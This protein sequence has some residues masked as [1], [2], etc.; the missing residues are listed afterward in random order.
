MS[1]KNLAGEAP[2]DRPRVRAD[3]NEET[4]W[5]HALD[6]APVGVT[7][8]D[9][10][11]PDRPLVYANDAVGQL[12]GY[13]TE[14]LLGRDCRFL[15]GVRGEST[16]E[17]HGPTA[18][19]HEA[20]DTGEAA[21]EEVKTERADG[22]TFWNEVTHVPIMAD[23]ELSS[24]VCFHRDVTRGRALER[25]HREQLEEL[26]TLDGMVSHS[27]R[28]DLQLVLSTLELLEKDVPA[29]RRGDI[30]AALD[31]THQAIA[32]AEEARAIAETVVASATDEL[33]LDHVIP[34]EVD[35][36]QQSSPG[37]MITV[38]GELPPVSVTANEMF[39]ALVRS[40]LE[41]EIVR[42]NATEPELVVSA[43]DDDGSVVVSVSEDGPEAGGET[44]SRGEMSSN[45]D[46]E[47]GTPKSGRVGLSLVRRLVDSYGGDV[48]DDGRAV[49]VTLPIGE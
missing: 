6:A 7:I 48:T 22:T 5:K 45:D 25:E 15:F 39:P 37:A 27:I 13:D 14:T 47:R 2:V 49:H 19:L 43:V 12:T 23:G 4:L 16:V 26:Q 17:K 9:G 30:E 11:D 36:V 46:P 33:R 32:L 21:R 35:Q 10:C 8:A 38:E 1:E 41:S 20:I 31:R 34:R 29:S 44:A 42:S 40:L 28:N 24:L 18:R 3:R